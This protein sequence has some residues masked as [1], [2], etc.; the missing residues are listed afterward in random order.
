MASKNS[1][2]YRVKGQKGILEK[3]FDDSRE[4]AVFCAKLKLL[5][6]GQILSIVIDGKDIGIEPDDG[7][8]QTASEQ[9]K[10]GLE[11]IMKDFDDGILS[12]CIFITKS[13]DGEVS[14]NIFKGNDKVNIME[15]VGVLYSTAQSLA[16]KKK[17]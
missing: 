10:N 12:S 16:E 8:P 14:S 9:F 17:V 7:E 4:M 1:V 11:K 2:K 3:E 5:E 13:K 15:W 6:E